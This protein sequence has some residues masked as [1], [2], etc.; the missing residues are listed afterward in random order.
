MGK[1][2]SA[3]KAQRRAKLIAALLETNSDTE[4]AQ[5]AGVSMSTLT[6]Y[7]SDPLFMGEWRDALDKLVDR[8]VD[9]ALQAFDQVVERMTETALH[10]S[11]TPKERIAAQREL[12][13][14]ALKLREERFVDQELRELR[15]IAQALGCVDVTPE[16]SDD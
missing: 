2:T 8:G 11:S 12:A 16:E 1:L 4:A 13:A 14:I 7:R 15:Q 5:R 10:E 3:T 9:R 6:R